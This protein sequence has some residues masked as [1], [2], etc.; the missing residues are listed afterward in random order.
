PPET[1][2]YFRRIQRALHAGVPLPVSWYAADNGDPN[3]T[4]EYRSIPTTPADADASGGHETLLDDYEADQV[5]GFGR[6]TAGTAATSDQ[7]NAALSDE[8]KIVFLRVKNSWGGRT[9]ETRAPAGH[10]DLYFEFL[11][12]KLRSCPK[13]EPTSDKCT[14]EVPL[15]DVTLPAGF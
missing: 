15:E 3:S 2:D 4:G 7:Q 8:T 14:D 1:R 13:D 12:G 5:P 11:T 10:N 9:G 6:L